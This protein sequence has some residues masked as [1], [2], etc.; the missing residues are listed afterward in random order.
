[1][2]EDG[3]DNRQRQSIP[4]GSLLLTCH[5][6]GTRKGKR[7]SHEDPSRFLGHLHPSVYGPKCVLPGVQMKY[8]GSSGMGEHCV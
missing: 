2:G 3:G 7:G 5:L 4:S 8:T 6:S 1:M